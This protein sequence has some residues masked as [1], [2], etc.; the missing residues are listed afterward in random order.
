MKYPLVPTLA[1]ERDPGMLCVL[2]YK[3]APPSGARA[4]EESG[5]MGEGEKRGRLIPAAVVDAVLDSE[6]LMA[7]A[8]REA[9]AIRE[10]A[11]QEGLRQAREEVAAEVA[12]LA[13][14]R[15]SLV[16]QAWEPLLALSRRLAERLVLAQLTLEPEAVERMAAEALEEVAAFGPLTLR[17]CAADHKR[18]E[19][20]VAGRRAIVA[21]QAPSSVWVVVDASL[22]SGDLVIEAEGLTLDGRLETRLELFFQAFEREIGRDHV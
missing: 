8:R 2:S 21:S 10:R 11:R 20:L 12:R 13:G 18:L 16:V 7:S 22:G 15:E 3:A 17:V 1:W 6:E 5:Q 9:E 14:R 19:D 4:W